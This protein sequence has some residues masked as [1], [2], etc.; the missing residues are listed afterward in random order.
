MKILVISSNVLNPYLGPSTVTYNLMNG[1][2]KIYHLLEKKDVEL[3]FLSLNERGIK[4]FGS[5]IKVVGAGYLPLTSITGE[6]HSL[7]SSRNLKDIDIVHSHYIIHLVPWIFTRSFTVL[8][9]HGVYWKE[10]YFNP[11]N[12]IRRELNTLLLDLRF[13]L[14]LKRLSRFIAISKYVMDELKRWHSI[15]SSKTVV[16]GN[17]IS[18]LFFEIK[19]NEAPMIIYPARLSPRKN[20]L[21]F[22]KALSLI[23]NEVREYKLLF[24]GD[25]DYYY[26]KIL[27]TFVKKNNLNNVSFTG[28][29]PYHQ[30][31]SYYSQASLMALTSFQETLPMSVLEAMATGTPPL[32]SS[33]GGLK[34]LIEDFVNGLRVDPYNEK[35]I[36]DK[37]LILLDD[38]NLRKRLSEN[39]R[40]TVE[41]YRS[42]K[43]ALK[44]LKLYE[45]LY[46]Q[47]D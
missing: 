6:L 21:K 39:A 16:I 36:A 3:I 10:K 44:H 7:V 27:E 33:V 42:D 22:I 29:I 31:R 2:Y 32:V 43:I 45:R 35:D 8:T 28:K 14:L 20:Q 11:I 38:K 26:R 19:R 1:F 25:G 30:L 17:P 9:L 15:V 41:E 5:R 37:L 40:K 13:E 4:D 12:P 23:K 46:T 18:D 47:G 24:I 34:Y